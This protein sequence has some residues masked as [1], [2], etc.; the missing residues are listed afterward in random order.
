VYLCLF[1]AS[2]ASRPLDERA[3][4][5]AAYG[6]PEVEVTWLGFPHWDPVACARLRGALAANG[7]RMR[8]I[9]APFGPDLNILSRDA[10]LAL[11]AL[12][13][14]LHMLP[15]VA[16]IGAETF[17]V[18]PGR[19]FAS[20]RSRESVAEPGTRLL[21]RVGERAGDLGVQVAVENMLPA[22]AMAPFDLLAEVVGRVDLPNVGICLDTGHAH[23][24]GSVTDAV[25]AFGS[26]IRHVH[27][28]DNHGS[29]DE[30]LAPT[31]GT[32]DWPGAVAALRAIDYRGALS[33]EC[34]PPPG[35]APAEYRA[36]AAH[37][38]E[39]Q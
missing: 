18:H 23:V 19:E 8:A 7:L 24:V 32:I 22:N 38:L 35:M 27:V 2:E 1:A 31:L 12:E 29:V 5:L 14:H 34:Q 26:R 30:H 25:A 10:G 3:P 6:V 28:H 21:R 39:L 4:E 33:L 13:S 36:F 20:E 15:G 37:A 16:A 11:H 9:H 17:V